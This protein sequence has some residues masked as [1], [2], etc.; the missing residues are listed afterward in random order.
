MHIILTHEQADF[1]AIASLL[2]AALLQ[3]RDYAL[4]PKK[5]NRNVSAFLDLYG[6]ELPLYE[7]GQLPQ[8]K[9]EHI[10]LVDTQSMVTLRGVGNNTTC[11]VVDHHPKKEGFPDQWSGTFRT[12][13][14]CVTIL[15]GD[16]L[17]KNLMLSPVQATLLLAGIYEDTGTLTYAS[18]SSEDLVAAAY[19]LQ[20]GASLAIIAEYLNPPLSSEQQIIYDNLLENIQALSIQGQQIL[21]SVADAQSINEEI[22]SIAHKIRD[23]L[24][25]D[26]LFLLVKTAEGIRLVA[27]SSSDQIDV[28][29]V[30][31]EFGGGGHTRAAAAFIHNQKAD[32]TLE[33]AYAKLISLIPEIIEP[34]IRVGDIMSKNPQL[35][36]LETSAKEASQLMQRYGYEGYPVINHGKIVGLLN[37]R[38][39]DRAINHKLNLPASSLMEAGTVFVHENSSLADVQRIMT[40]SGWGQLPVLSSQTKEIIGIVTRTDLIKALGK[41]KGLNLDNKDI[42]TLLQNNLLP[43][44]INFLQLIAG[45]SSH[46]KM[47]IYLVGGFVRDLLLHHASFDFDF[48]V[49]G[50]AISLAKSLQS[51]YQG[52]ISTHKRFGT[53]K[54]IIKDNSQLL[55]NLPEEYVKFDLEKFP[56]S[57]DF[58]S[59]RT[60]FYTY[61]TALP[62]VERSSIKLDLHRRDFSI[63]TL[64]LRLDGRHFG[65]LYDYWGGLADLENGLIRVLH[66]LSFV[67]DPTRL[68]RAVRFE[69]RFQFA[70]ETRTLQLLTEATDLIQQVSGDRLRHELNLILQ[71]KNPLPALN[72]LD[73]LGLLKSIHPDLFF[74]EPISW[75]II[76]ILDSTIEP[77]WGIPENIGILTAQAALIYITWFSELGKSY[78]SICKRLRMPAMIAENITRNRQFQKIAGNLT[79]LKPSEITESL[80]SYPHFVLFLNFILCDNENLRQILLKFITHWQMVKPFTNGE[81]LRDRGIKP[82][83]NYKQIL[84]QLRSA[85]LDEEITTVEQELLLLEAILSNE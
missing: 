65:E 69:Q 12:T 5:I 19:L 76:K 51:T 26:A 61:P 28:S 25:A 47:P 23:L 79:D 54:W 42:S 78:K 40:D 34:T 24:D 81:D 17:Q 15:I 45:Q 13:G 21:V 83:P 75:K 84:N 43:D 68:I 60:E 16:I 55:I 39:V 38:S 18:T 46:L 2:A 62:E 71:E 11:H 44:H 33:N 64:A 67:D 14:A 59:A 6:G 27:R 77:W 57:L 37:R 82:G 4:L 32:V 70:I 8:K 85:W 3:E 41:P 36:T 49:E 52:K 73:G 56:Q 66:S 1:D 7:F 72:R 10:T 35:I 9:I 31:R 80:E 48:V 20:N 50:D 58:I 74:R 22:S 63:N 29:K 53:A 30:A